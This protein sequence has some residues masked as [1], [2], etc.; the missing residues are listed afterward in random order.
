[1]VWNLN[2]KAYWSVKSLYHHIV[3]SYLILYYFLE[4]DFDEE[5]PSLCCLFLRGRLQREESF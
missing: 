4:V 3:E 1:M 2:S 5:S